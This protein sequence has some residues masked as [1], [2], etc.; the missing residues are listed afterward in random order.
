[1][2]VSRMLT[3]ILLLFLVEHFLFSVGAFSRSAARNGQMLFFPDKILLE[4]ELRSYL[5][6]TLT[7]LIFWTLPLLVMFHYAIKH[8]KIR[9]VLYVAALNV[10]S[11][12]IVIV[13]LSM[14]YFQDLIR[15]PIARITIV[16]AFVSPF[17]LNML[18]FTRGYI[19]ELVLASMGDSH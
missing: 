6:L 7:R 14:F 18:P 9:N 1:M 8:Y 17:I 16:L 13:L 10:S 11:N 12:I 2:K 4:I 15:L 3:I 19:R 5:A